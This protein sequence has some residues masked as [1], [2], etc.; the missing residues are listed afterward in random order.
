MSK[1]IF[2]CESDLPTYTPHIR[3]EFDDS[4]HPF[5]EDV[6]SAFEQFLLGVTFQPGSI[7]KYINMEAV[8]ASRLEMAL[9]VKE[10]KERMAA[11]QAEQPAAA[12]KPKR[13][14]RR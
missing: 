1:Y 14:K 10:L 3:V 2:I 6:L 8:H 11:K 5:L 7:S 4:E 9:A 12:E 13:K